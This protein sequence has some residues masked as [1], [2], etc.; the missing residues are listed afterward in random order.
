MEKRTKKIAILMAA[1]LGAATVLSAC[2]GST[3]PA[4][5]A[6]AET[7]EAAAEET[8]SEPAAETAPAETA[9]AGE[10]WPAVT[11]HYLNINSESMGG[12]DIQAL[13][14]KFNETN[15]KNITVEF[16]FISGLYA[17][18][19]STVQS[20][21]MA[22]EDVGV[23]QCGYS[24]LNYYAENFPQMQDINDVIAN[25]DPDNA[26]F[27]DEY[28]EDNVLQMGLAVNGKQVGLPYAMSAPVLYYNADMFKAAGLDPENPPKTWEE[29]Y[30]ASKKIKEATGEY[31]VAIQNPNDTY[32]VDPIFLSAGS[33]ML[34][35]EA[36]NYEAVFYNE[37]SVYAWTLLQNMTKEGL[38]VQ[39][40]M[41]DAVA[42]F[43]GG[44]VAMFLTTSG[45][46]NYFAQSCNFDVRTCFQPT[47]DGHELKVCI[48]G[49]VLGIVG[50]DPA[51]I[52]A[53]WEF[54]KFLLSPENV[55]VECVATG[56]LPPTKNCLD[57]P[58]LQEFLTSNHLITTAV[59][60]LAYATQWI[61]WPGK[62]GLNIDQY[63][64]NMRD[65]ILSNMAD[66]DSTIKS[67]QDQVNEA[68]KN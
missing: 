22:G 13:V 7:Q 15:G 61:S 31:G 20:Y 6:P 56:Y 1:L 40:T 41:D 11:I 62:N 18:I 23:V 64:I 9:P 4:A 53:S 59:D 30:E 54:V 66:V 33:E 42:A 37:N 68:L 32:S 14:Q 27:L 67:T 10:E 48:G 57:D 51:T 3:A 63:L 39:I 26:N 65:A 36:G 2:G 17:E 44:K 55:A 49:N 19:A 58:A 34:A 50:E 43:A 16:D 8:A 35:G 52:R 38:H 28:Y 12:P 25:Y 5:P 60:E 21:L 47:F 46:V 24:Y 29:V 45:R